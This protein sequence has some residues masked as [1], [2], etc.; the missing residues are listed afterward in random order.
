MVTLDLR[1]HQSTGVV[2]QKDIGWNCTSDTLYFRGIAMCFLLL[3][4]SR[5][6]SFH[7]GLLR[8]L[9]GDLFFEVCGLWKDCLWLT[10]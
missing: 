4:F 10:A 5:V 8:N 2:V 1:R 6:N 7:S 9:A 3:K